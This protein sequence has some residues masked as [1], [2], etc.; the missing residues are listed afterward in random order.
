[1]RPTA[2]LLLLALAAWAAVIVSAGVAAMSA[3]RGLPG[4]GISVA[5]TEGFFAGDTEEMGRFAAGRMLQPVFAAAD[6]VQF[7]A[8]SLSVG[9]TVR[10][11]RL[12]GF[13]GG[14]WARAVLVGAV[15]CAA[16][17]LAW[18]AW[19]APAMDADLRAY[20][21]AVGQ[22]DADAARTARAS[23]DAA[24]RT[25]DAA[26]R[27]QLALVTAA[28]VAFVPAVLPAPGARADAPR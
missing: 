1:M 3:F 25:A 7:A 24:H 2:T 17:L 21:D 9:C 22:G 20:W 18:R 5:G 23:F 15:A 16:T 6:W 27:V 10:M 19:G 8:S 26:F 13:R 14:R 4:L 11:A 12:G 28:L